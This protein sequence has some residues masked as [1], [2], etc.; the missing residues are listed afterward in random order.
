ML[1]EFASEAGGFGFDVPYSKFWEGPK[2]ACDC[3]QCLFSKGAKVSESGPE[4]DI[5]SYGLSP[6]SLADLG[7]LLTCDG[8]VEEAGQ[9]PNTPSHHSWT[10]SYSRIFTKAVF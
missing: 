4:A 2:A 7:S 3:V 5:A 8:A 10:P 1:K 6:Q 9:L